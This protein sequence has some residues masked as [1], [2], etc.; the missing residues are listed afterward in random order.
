MWSSGPFFGLLGQTLIL[1]RDSEHSLFG[2]LVCQA[3]RQLALFPCAIT[4]VFRI[5]D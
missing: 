4:P 1:I 5:V 3:L 2:L